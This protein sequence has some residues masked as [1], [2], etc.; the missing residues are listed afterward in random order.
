VALGDDVLALAVI[1]LHQRKTQPD[2]GAGLLGRRLD[3]AA[4]LS[5]DDF[6]FAQDFG[7]LVLCF[8]RLI[9]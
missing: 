2:G 1:I 3:A 7:L 4:P 9:S 5:V 6:L 8:F